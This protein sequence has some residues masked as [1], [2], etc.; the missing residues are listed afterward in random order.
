MAIS[1]FN[2]GT[3]DFAK[4]IEDLL[5]KVAEARSECNLSLCSTVDIDRLTDRC[6]CFMRTEN[7]A[8]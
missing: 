4:A 7:V 6:I 1:S 8:L 3:D 2:I 5:K